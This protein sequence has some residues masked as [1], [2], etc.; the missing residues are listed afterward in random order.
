[1]KKKPV[2]ARLPYILIL[3]LDATVVGDVNYVIEEHGLHHALR[4]KGISSAGFASHF[5]ESFRS[6]LLRPYF[7]EFIQG[8][9]AAYDG[10]EVFVFSAGSDTWVPTIIGEI[11][12][13]CGIRVHRPYFSRKDTHIGAD[14]NGSFSYTKSI[15]AT[16]EKIFRVLEDDYKALRKPEAREHVTENRVLMLDDNTSVIADHTDRH[17][18]IPEYKFVYAFDITAGL[19]DAVRA[20]PEVTEYMK[21]FTKSG[22]VAD[23][24]YA[25]AP[26]VGDAQTSRMTYY[27]AMAALIERKMRANASSAEDRVFQRL[28]KMMVKGGAPVYEEWPKR[29]VASIQRRLAK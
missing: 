29:V 23:Y 20:L 6:G 25:P 27:L 9:Q 28:L 15:T 11:E 21:A 10:L 19:P 13:F 14:Q 3:D 1:M 2:A 24:P 16:L 8:L 12:K 4:Q 18:A 5:A 7:C 26:G 22:T 17:L